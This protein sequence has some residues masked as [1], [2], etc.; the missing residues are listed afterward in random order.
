MSARELAST[1]V[2]EGKSSTY[3]GMKNE[4]GWQVGEHPVVQYNTQNW[5]G[6]E[7]EEGLEGP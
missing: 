7:G 5:V 3:I 2:P 6:E 4:T 1:N